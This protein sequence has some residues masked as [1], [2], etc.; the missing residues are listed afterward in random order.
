MKKIVALAACLILGAGLLHAQ[1]YTGYFYNNYEGVGGIT[2]NPA[3]IAGSVYKL[4]VNIFSASGYFGTNAYEV[5]KSTLF[6]F[7]FSGWREGNHYKRVNNSDSKDFWTNIDILGPSV[8]VAINEK[9]SVALSTRFR[10][11]ANE[12][13]LSNDVFQLFGKT[14]PNAIYGQALRQNNL[15][16]DAHAFADI[17]LTYG[18]VLFENDRHKLKVGA[19]AKWVLGLGAGSLYGDNVNVN[20]LDANNITTLTGSASIAYSTG[21]DRLID[22]NLDGGLGSYIDARGVGFDLGVVYEWTSAANRARVEEEGNAWFSPTGYK[23][24]IS[25]SVT[26]IGRLKYDVV[27]N[28]ASYAL[29]FSGVPSDILN[30]GDRSLDEYIN[31]LKAGGYISQSG[32]SELKP[33]LP[34]LLHAN[35][36]WQAW[37]RFYVNLDGALNLVGDKKMGARYLSGLALT[38]RY[39]S[40]WFSVYSP[41][42]YNEKDEFGWGLGF[43]VGVFY[44]GS[45]SI[46]SNVIRSDVKSAD[47]HVGMHVPIGRA[48]KVKSKPIIHEPVYIPEPEPPRVDTVIQIK[49]VIKYIEP[50]PI[51]EPVKVDEVIVK[52]VELLA[53]SIYFVTGSDWL[54]IESREPLN[55]IAE[56]LKANPDI[57]ATIEGHADS[58]GS[59][60]TNDALSQRRADRIASYLIEQGVDTWRISTTAYGSHRPFAANL[61]NAGKAKNRRVEIRLHYNE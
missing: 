41:V 40:R 20:L 3:N 18:G 42:T 27:S 60:A 22:G 31:D 51:P 1:S 43:N 2:A 14:E 50:E 11:L 47:F 21:I 7:K 44:V 37:K 56:I 53:H 38:P 58:V 19:T 6:K 25:A 48:K 59:D 49:E 9:H 55:R 23:L 28:S 29:N 52:E 57:Y 16:V 30:L 54:L 35:V 4:D 24:R 36:D 5:K 12:R 13:N 61:T 39:E 46:L 10:F 17:G 34:T 15:R 26:D 33:S 8:M 45:S 32:I